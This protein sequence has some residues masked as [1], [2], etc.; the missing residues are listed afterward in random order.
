MREMKITQFFQKEA[1]RYGNSL[2][3]QKITSKMA[4]FNHIKI[5]LNTYGLNLPLK[6]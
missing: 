5:M 6:R 3:N 2:N 4:Y 1:E